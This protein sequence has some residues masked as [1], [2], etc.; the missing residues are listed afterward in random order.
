MTHKEFTAKL[1]EFCLSHGFEIAG[2]CESEGIYGE[3]AVCKVGNDPGWHNWDR[4]KFN[5]SYWDID[6]EKVWNEQKEP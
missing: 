5:F 6:E 3:I 4:N 1:R 2:T